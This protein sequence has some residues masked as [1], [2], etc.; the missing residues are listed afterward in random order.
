MMYGMHRVD[1]DKNVPKLDT[2][3]SVYEGATK[4]IKTLPGSA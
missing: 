3:R 1:E 2:A 4:D